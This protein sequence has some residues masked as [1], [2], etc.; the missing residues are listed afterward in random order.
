MARR[1]YRIALGSAAECSAAVDLLG[2]YGVADPEQGRILVRRVGAM[3]RR[4]VG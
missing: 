3:L 2:I 4:M 1:H